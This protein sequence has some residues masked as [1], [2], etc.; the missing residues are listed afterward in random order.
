MDFR[1]VDRQHNHF[2]SSVRG[3]SL[4]Q[5]SAAQRFNVWQSA[6][7]CLFLI[8]VACFLLPKFNLG[9]GTDAQT[10]ASTIADALEKRDAESPG[11]PNELVPRPLAS[12]NTAAT[13]SANNTTQQSQ[14]DDAFVPPSAA[15]S[16]NNA[17]FSSF[18]AAEEIP[19]TFGE[20]PELHLNAS[21]IAK[22]TRIGMGKPVL[23]TCL[24]E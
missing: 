15:K 3:R 19:A 22:P 7:V 5:S 23:S 16:S 13:K 21:S 9:L 17:T 14:A 12:T 18:N 24:H 6:F 20:K 2:R 8:P 11:E 4:R 1:D 10:I